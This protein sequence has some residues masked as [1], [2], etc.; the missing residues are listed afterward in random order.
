[1]KVELI[2]DNIRLR[3]IQLSDLDVIHQLHS[4]PEI[5]KYNT[6]GIPKDIAEIKAIIKPWIDA[7]QLEEIKTYTFAIETKIEAEFIGLFGFKIGDKKYKRAEVWYKIDSNHWQKGYATTALKAVL[8]FGFTILKLHRI[9][10]GC[11]VD[12]IASIKVLEK[13]GMIR[14]GRGREILP[15]QSGWSD[16][17]KYAILEND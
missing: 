15:L 8:D 10:A 9:E 17:Y 7:N 6:L 13:V 4:L 14:E 16:N 5:D 1:M 3:L 2:T 12:N 11:A